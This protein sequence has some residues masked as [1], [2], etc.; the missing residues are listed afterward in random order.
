MREKR[1]MRGIRL[2]MKDI[3]GDGKLKHMLNVK[4][5]GGIRK[6]RVY[7]DMR[8][9]GNVRVVKG[10]RIGR[11]YR[12]GHGGRAG[13]GRGMEERG[14]VRMGGRGGGERTGEI[15]GER[16]PVGRGRGRHLFSA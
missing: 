12:E 1:M 16:P 14:V 15:V 7:R 2:V 3:S 11:L 4:F 5:W 8:V 13:Q 9:E 10:V 6:G